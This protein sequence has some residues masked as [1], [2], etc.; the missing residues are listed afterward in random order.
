MPREKG[1]EATHLQRLSSDLR[2]PGGSRRESSER[3]GATPRDDLHAGRAQRSLCWVSWPCCV[4]GSH[5]KQEAVS[6]LTGG[7]RALTR[8]HRPFMESQIQRHCFLTVKLIRPILENLDNRQNYE[9]SHH[10]VDMVEIINFMYV[11]SAAF[12]TSSL[13]SRQFSP[14]H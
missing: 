12:K 11:F 7:L 6:G 8:E 13:Y 4:S 5:G 14:H 9:E 3:D 1:E 2:E 10:P